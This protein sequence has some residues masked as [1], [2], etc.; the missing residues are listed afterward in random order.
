V[1]RMGMP[2]GSSPRRGVGVGGGVYRNPPNPPHLASP[3]SGGEDHESLL[4]RVERRHPVPPGADRVLVLGRPAARFHAAR[5]H[6]LDVVLVAL[7]VHRPVEVLL[8]EAFAL[9][10]KCRAPLVLDVALLLRLLADL[11]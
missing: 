10:V 8:A 3:P 4:A 6:A 1:G 11:G 5:R 7:V 9:A 2:S